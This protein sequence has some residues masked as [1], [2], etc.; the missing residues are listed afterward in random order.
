MSLI[1]SIIKKFDK[2]THAQQM[3]WVKIA[4]AIAIA[5]MFAIAWGVY[6]LQ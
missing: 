5:A 6:N 1:Q 3:G 2:M 4:V